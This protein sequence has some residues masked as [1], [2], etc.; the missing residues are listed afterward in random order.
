MMIVGVFEHACEIGTLV[1][2]AVSGL[3]PVWL[4]GN[5]SPAEALQYE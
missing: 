3:Y 5:L 1:L 2:G 4:A